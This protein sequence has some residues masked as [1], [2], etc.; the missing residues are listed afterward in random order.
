MTNL[1]KKNDA[2]RINCHIKHQYLYYNI[3]INKTLFTN[4]NPKKNKKFNN[5]ILIHIRIQLK[6][7]NRPLSLHSHLQ[8]YLINLH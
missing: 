4:Y 6:L 1:K 3:K 5:F 8:I 2:I 7:F